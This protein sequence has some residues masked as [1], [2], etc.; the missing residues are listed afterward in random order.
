MSDT[1]QPPVGQFLIS[2]ADTRSYTYIPADSER[3]S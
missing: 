2:Y 3:T 1:L